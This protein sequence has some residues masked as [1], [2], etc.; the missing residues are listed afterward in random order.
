MAKIN[1]GILG[2]F[3]GKIGSV[4]G[5]TWRGKNIIRSAPSVSEKPPSAAQLKQRNKF[6]GILKFLTPIKGI[7]TKTFGVNIGSKIPFGNAMSYHLKEA[8]EKSS[9][10]FEIA[11]AKVLIAK[12]EL[13][14]LDNVV[15]KTQPTHSIEVS[16]NDNSNQGFAYPTDAFILVAYAPSLKSFNYT[17][18]DSLRDHEQCV[19]NFEESFYGETVHVWAT[20]YNEKLAIAATS[21]YLGRFVIT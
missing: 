10:D 7:L 19:F 17:M 8:V 15:V 1:Q 20:F 12:G 21:T 5:S 9:A 13:C 11:Y 14:G 16:W 2:G 3:S 4:V 6:S 18:G